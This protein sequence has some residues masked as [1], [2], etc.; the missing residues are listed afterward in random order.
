MASD[1]DFVDSTFSEDLSQLVK[2]QSYPLWEILKGHLH[3]QEEQDL[4]V[5][6]A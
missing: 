2:E 1:G 4:R 5:E 6:M 3:L